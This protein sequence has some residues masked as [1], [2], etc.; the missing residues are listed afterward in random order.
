L[1][2]LRAS[3]IASAP[4]RIR[5]AAANPQVA[6]TLGRRMRDRPP[7]LWRHARPRCRQ[8]ASCCEPTYPADSRGHGGTRIR[9]A[10]PPTMCRPA[11]R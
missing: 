1:A 5:S 4:S 11:G 9:G 7:G 2:A 6:A 10:I 8:T 3:A